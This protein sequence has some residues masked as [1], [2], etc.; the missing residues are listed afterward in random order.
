MLQ[1]QRKAE[2]RLYQRTRE[3]ILQQRSKISE[4]RPLSSRSLN[5]EQAVTKWK[6]DPNLARQNL[7]PQMRR[8]EIDANKGKQTLLSSSFPRLMD[9]ADKHSELSLSPRSRHRALSTLSPEYGGVTT[10]LPDINAASKWKR[11]GKIVRDTIRPWKLSDTQLDTG[12]PSF[13]KDA[14]TDE[15][16]KELK[17]CR[18]LRT[19]SARG[20]LSK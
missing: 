19:V 12:R 8:K 1:K 20:E 10:S 13:D 17:N 4:T 2:E 9:H 14:I 11:G 6:S 16:W 7:S 15:E 3:Y 5:I 18:Y